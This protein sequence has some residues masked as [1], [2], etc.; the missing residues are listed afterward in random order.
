EQSCRA[1]IVMLRRRRHHERRTTGVLRVRDTR[2]AQE[3][4]PPK[5]C[6]LKLRGIL[7]IGAGS[8]KHI[9]AVLLAHFMSRQSLIF[10]GVIYF[11]MIHLFSQESFTGICR[12]RSDPC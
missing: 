12:T 1:I 8:D 3:S 4:V 5:D 6:Q 9:F 7:A 11:L 2:S 10:S